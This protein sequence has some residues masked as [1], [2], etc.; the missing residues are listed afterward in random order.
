MLK[1]SFFS[2]FYTFFLLLFYAIKTGCDVT[3]VS[4]RLDLREF[5]RDSSDF[6]QTLGLN[7]VILQSVVC[8][9][10]TLF[11]WVCNFL[12]IILHTITFNK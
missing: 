1:S 9:M 8:I 3:I 6:D 7:N 12:Y 5:G 11:N 4:L 10:C 2:F